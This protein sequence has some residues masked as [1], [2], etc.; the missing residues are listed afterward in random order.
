MKDLGS[1]LGI[2]FIITFEFLSIDP[3][4]DPNYEF[5]EDY[6]NPD[7]KLLRNLEENDQFLMESENKNGNENLESV[8]ENGNDEICEDG[9]SILIEIISHLLKWSDQKLLTIN[10]NLYSDL[11]NRVLSIVENSV[12]NIYELYEKTEKEDA[13]DYGYSY[14]EKKKFVGDRGIFYFSDDAGRVLLIRMIRESLLSSCDYNDT[15]NHTYSKLNSVND[16]C[17]DYNHDQNNGNNINNNNYSDQ[18]DNDDNNNNNN[19]NNNDNDVINTQPTSNKIDKTILTEKQKIRSYFTIIFNTILL[20]IKKEYT[21]F[22]TKRNKGSENVPGTIRVTHVLPQIPSTSAEY[23]AKNV[24][25]KIKGV[26]T[27][28]VVIVADD[29]DTEEHS[30]A[31]MN[32]DDDDLIP[33]K[34]PRITKK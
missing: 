13:E 28:R 33:K 21:K 5:S 4:N 6:K 2:L 23:S 16:E 14:E 26:R 20:L 7:K 3:E 10:D 17:D 15:F 29:E 18:N 34:K 8:I 31:Y 24:P 11:K 22:M 12:I 25:K 27:F 9:L 19:N 32:D 30:A 1:L